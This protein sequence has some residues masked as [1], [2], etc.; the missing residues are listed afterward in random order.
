MISEQS[1]ML[2]CV[3]VSYRSASIE[4]RERAA[5]TISQQD[6][7]YADVRAHQASGIGNLVIVSTCNRTELYAYAP[8][9]E[10]ETLFALLLRS[11]QLRREELAQSAYQHTGEMALWHLL[12]VAAGLDS[13]TVGEPQIL[14]QIVRSY[15]RAVQEKTISAELARTMQAAIRAGKRVRG[16]T[17]LGNGA[18]SLGTLAAREAEQ[19]V[20]DLSQATAL[21]VGAG[22][23]ARAAVKALTVRHV[24][25]LIVANRTVEKAQALVSQHHGEAIS[26]D[27]IT[28]ILPQVDVVITATS[29]AEA[30]LC[31]EDVAQAQL[32]RGNRPLAIL[33]LG[34]PRNVDPQVTTVWGVQLRD[35]DALQKLAGAAIT[36]RQQWIPQAESILCEELERLLIWLRER[37]AVTEIRHLYERAQ[38]QRISELD[39]LWQQL[40]HLEIF[41]R[42]EIEKFSRRMINK[43]LHLHVM[44]LKRAAGRQ[45]EWQWQ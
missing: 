3:G 4:Q 44:E 32:Q 25:R 37:A 7:L 41:E 36:R 30:W 19:V 15:E 26:L 1:P 24:G 6:R 5:L 17:G 42:V 33:D 11:S 9:A 34:L 13:Q 12:R 38:Q 2:L 27:G 20:G 14:G 39:R 22:S 31:A 18:S 23:M 29:T 10:R 16:E 45:S 35:L 40:P 28:A 21:I 43:T 8:E